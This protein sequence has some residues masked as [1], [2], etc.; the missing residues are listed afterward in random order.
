[1]LPS[2]KQQNKDTVAPATAAAL[3]KQQAEANRKIAELQL[4]LDRAEQEHDFYLDK[5]RDV[6]IYCQVSSP[7]HVLERLPLIT[8]HVPPD[9]PRSEQSSY[10]GR[11]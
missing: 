8:C 2:G 5:L 11:D 7:R 10:Q 6:E 9:T 1:M 3:G 4:R